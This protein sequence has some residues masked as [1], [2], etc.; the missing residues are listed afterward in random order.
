MTPRTLFLAIGALMGLVCFACWSSNRR[1]QATSHH[2][3]V[4][5]GLNKEDRHQSDRAISRL[6]RQNR[7][8]TIAVLLLALDGSDEKVHARAARALT[9]HRAENDVPDEIIRHLLHNPTA[10]ARVSCAIGLMQMETPTVCDAFIQA[11]DDEEDKVV[12]IAC[13]EVGHRGG[14]GA[15]EA[16]FRKLNHPSWDVRLEVCKALIILKAT[17][18]RVVRELESMCQEP[19]AAQYDEFI[20][21]S[22]Q[23]DKELEKEM[24]PLPPEAMEQWGKIGEILDQAREIADSREV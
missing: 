1:S 12:Q 24:G 22:N 10:R 6:F 7:K 13:V 2:E 18:T 8:E 21:E 4:L 3:K 14:N 9:L 23:M 15:A 19:E 16:L 11:L 17:D 5:E 20:E